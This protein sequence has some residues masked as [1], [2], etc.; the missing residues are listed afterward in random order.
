[1]SIFLIIVI[2]LLAFIAYQ[3]YKRKPEEKVVAKSNL[4]DTF[5]GAFS[6]AEIEAQQQKDL[7]LQEDVAKSFERMSQLEKIEIAQH[8]KN[9]GSKEDFTPSQQLI[10]AITTFDHHIDMRQANAGYASRMIEANAAVLNGK[11]IEQVQKEVWAHTPNLGLLDNALAQHGSGHKKAIEERK[12]YWM[13]HW[14]S[15]A[16]ES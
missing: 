7:R 4:R 14:G 16:D 13:N 6:E 15:I 12:D 2:L 11:S 1:M 10:A 5:C 8:S 9:G 3:V